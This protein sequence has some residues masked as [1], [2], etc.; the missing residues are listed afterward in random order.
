MESGSSPTHDGIAQAERRTSAGDGSRGVVARTA[1]GEPS[2]PSPA[3]PSPRRRFDTRRKL[4]AAFL[5]L[6]AAFSAAFASQLAG[7]RHMEVHLAQ[8]QEHDE[9]ARLT[10]ELE[11]A[12]ETQLDQQALFLAGDRSRL[13]E[14]R[15]ARARTAYLVAELDRRV[16]E[17]E[18]DRWLAEIHETT[19]ELDRLLQGQIA[20]GAAAAAAHDAR[21]TL[22]RRVEAN[23]DKLFAFL[24]GESMKYHRH[25]KEQE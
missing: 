7:L 6:A 5:L 14:Y 13:A 3:V 23:V 18:V 19:A 24:R 10:V 12:I 2:L 22:A 16:D 17:P 4:L 21:S 20:T 11:H 15:E 25:L 9:Q 8:L 1:P